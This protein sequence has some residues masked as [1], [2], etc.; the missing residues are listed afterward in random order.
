MLVAAALSDPSVAPPTQFAIYNALAGPKQLFVLAT[1]HAEN[2]A[3]IAQEHNLLDALTRFFC[4]DES[5][6]SPLV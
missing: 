5:R 6:V 3:R 1:G 4:G 2:P